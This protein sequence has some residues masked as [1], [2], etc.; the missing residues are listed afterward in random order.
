MSRRIA[1]CGAASCRPC[2][3]SMMPGAGEQ[4]RAP[5]GPSRTASLHATRATPYY[6]HGWVGVDCSMSLPTA[7]RLHPHEPGDMEEK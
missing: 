5:T 7:S 6:A 1:A 2:G 3:V 4:T